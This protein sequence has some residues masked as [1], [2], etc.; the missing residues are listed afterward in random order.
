[1][2]NAICKITSKT[3]SNRLSTVLPNVISINQ[4]AFIKGRNQADNAHVGLELLYH[5]HRSSSNPLAVKLDLSKVFDRVEWDLL[6]YL[7]R[8][9]NFSKSF[10]LFIH[11]CIASTH[12]AI[13]FNGSKTPYFHPTRGTSSRGPPFSITVYYLHRIFLCNF[14]KGIG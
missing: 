7:L 6:I 4:C 10:V 2:C 11:K 5:V 1:M 8:R 3:V 13:R 14:K 12:M 9:M